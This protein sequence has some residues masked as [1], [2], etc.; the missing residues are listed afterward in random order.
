MN[1]K[2]VK[3]EAV[4]EVMSVLARFDKIPLKVQLAF[5]R[6]LGISKIGI[7]TASTKS[8]SSENQSVNEGGVATYSVLKT[9]DRFLRVDVD[10]TTCYIP[11]YT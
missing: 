3:Q 7:I 1:E 8:A 4:K 5:K 2:I 10:G 6:A 9:P 11:V